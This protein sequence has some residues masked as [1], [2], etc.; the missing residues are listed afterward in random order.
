M[1]TIIDYGV[2]NI[3]A[4]LNVFK[5]LNIPAIAAKEKSEIEHA[6]KLIL[7]GVGAFDHAMERLNNSG[8]REALDRAVL[9]NQIPVLGI[10][11]GMQMLAASSDEGELPGLGWIDG[12]V[13]KFDV[14]NMK[15]LTHLP[16]MGW[17]DVL[18]VGNHS[19]FDELHVDAQ[20]YFLHSYYFHCNNANNIL[21]MADYGGNFTCAVGTDN[22]YGVQFHPEK[23]HQNGI[24][25][26]KNFANLVNA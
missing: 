4:F 11:V 20:F 19:L 8:M 22:I 21:A 9:K 18:P 16:H 24:Q 2:G 14:S 6:T 10:C 15:Q 23:S 17:N 12:T 3:K 7:P 13:K 5:Q 1:I 26:L 25:L